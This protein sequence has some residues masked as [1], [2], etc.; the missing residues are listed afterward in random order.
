MK[1][2][3]IDMARLESANPIIHVAMELGIR[4]RGNTGECFRS[5]RHSDSDDKP[6]LFFNLVKNT[7]QCRGCRDVGGSVVDL[8]CQYRGWDKETAIKWLAHR[9]E[10]DRMTRERYHGKGRK[11]PARAVLSQDGGET[12]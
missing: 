5:D 6:T 4:V 3:D 7:F 1:I 2:E 11:K 8:V 12:P 9:T 10:F